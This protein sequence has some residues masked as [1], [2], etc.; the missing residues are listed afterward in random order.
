MPASLVGAL[1]VTERSGSP[2]SR[3]EAGPIEQSLAIGT[4]S[5]SSKRPEIVDRIEDFDLSGSVPE[6]GLIHGGDAHRGTQVHEQA[7]LSDWPDSTVNVILGPGMP[8][9]LMAAGAVRGFGAD[10]HPSNAL[11]VQMPIV[12]LVRGLLEQDKVLA[13]RKLLSLASAS[14]DAETRAEIARLRRVL[15]PPI[16]SRTS[17]ADRDRSRE[18]A[19]LSRHASEYRGRWVAIDGDELIAHAASLKELRQA[20]SSTRNPLIHYVG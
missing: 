9:P 8:R 12:G 13:A 15:A 6:V 1:N 7:F 19:W 16:V 4:L 20:I 18:H 3:A 11:Q 17:V 5:V 2:W 14:E 10:R